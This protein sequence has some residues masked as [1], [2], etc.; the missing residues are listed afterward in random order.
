LAWFRREDHF[1]L[2]DPAAPLGDCV[3][4]QVERETGRRPDG[5]IRLLTQLRWFGHC[6]NPISIYYC[7]GAGGG[8]VALLAEVTN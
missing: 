6:F 4:A 2:G 1:H 5:P 7:Y 3:R 8:L